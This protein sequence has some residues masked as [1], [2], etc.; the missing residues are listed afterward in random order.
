MSG[1]LKT[2]AQIWKK[3]DIIYL[4]KE[5]QMSMRHISRFLNFHF[6]SIRNIISAFNQQGEESLVQCTKPLQMQ[7]LRQEFELFAISHHLADG[8]SH[9]YSKR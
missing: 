1:E 7:K 2:L 8:F 5:H 9:R 3:I 6:T 4:N